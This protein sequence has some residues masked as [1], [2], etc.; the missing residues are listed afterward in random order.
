MNILFDFP[1][2][3]KINLGQH[4]ENFVKWLIHNYDFFFDAI[5]D[6]VLHIQRFFVWYNLFYTPYFAKIET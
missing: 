4:V 5:K 3:L 2:F 1:E 6:G